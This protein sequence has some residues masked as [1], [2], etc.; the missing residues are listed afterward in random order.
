VG[1]DNLPALVL[2]SRVGFKE[3]GRRKGYYKRPDSP[4]VD[5]LNLVLPLSP[6]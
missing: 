3:A 2:Y 1:E 4:A 6:A 5:A